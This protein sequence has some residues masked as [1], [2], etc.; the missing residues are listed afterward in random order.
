MTNYMRIEPGTAAECRTPLAPLRSDPSE[1]SQLETQI[2]YGQACDILE[3]GNGDWIRIK[4]DGEEGWADRKHF[5]PKKY[6]RKY[7]LTR[8]ITPVETL[9]G[10][11]LLPF[12][13]M[14]TQ[15]E[16][17]QITESKESTTCTKKKPLDFAPLFE[18]APYLWGGKSILGID[19]SGYMQLIFGA[20]GIHLPRNA[21]Q[22][23]SLGNP[24]EFGHRQSGDLAFFSNDKG[25]IIHVGIIDEE[26]IWHASGWVHHDPITAEGI[27]HFETGMITHRLASIK[28]I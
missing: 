24:I 18:N 2:L 28:R 8:L 13:S 25:K 3:S 1:M 10:T 22:Q 4:V 17:Q 5:Y 21:S 19:C 26:G 27:V 23:E 6:T 20:C 16:E 12:G 15:E 14:L 11:Q 7:F 9:Y